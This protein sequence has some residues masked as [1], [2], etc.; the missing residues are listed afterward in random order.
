MS[1]IIVI[2]KSYVPVYCQPHDMWKDSIQ[3]HQ[4]DNSLGV[5]RLWGQV[6]WTL[7]KMFG[8]SFWGK[9]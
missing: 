8:D 1:Y 7:P 3:N 5:S 4:C 6:R 2:S 9:E